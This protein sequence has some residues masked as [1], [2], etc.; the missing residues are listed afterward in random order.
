MPSRALC[1]GVKNVERCRGGLE[2]A[3]WHTG[4]AHAAHRKVVM[5]AM[6]PVIRRHTRVDFQCDTTSAAAMQPSAFMRAPSDSFAMSISSCNFRA[7]PSSSCPVLVSG[8]EAKERCL[9]MDASV[10][11][12]AFVTVASCGFAAVARDSAPGRRCAVF[13]V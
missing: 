5:I 8:G 3:L 6:N 4:C 13:V 2:P 1:D 7:T 10:M 11:R 9:R 12:D